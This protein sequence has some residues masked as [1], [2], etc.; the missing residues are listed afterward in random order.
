[1]LD[2]EKGITV[3]YQH[4][5]FNELLILNSCFLHETLCSLTHFKWLLFVKLVKV[6]YTQRV[7]MTTG[8]HN[9]SLHNPDYNSI[10][11][12][13][14]Q[15]VIIFCQHAFYRSLRAETYVLWSVIINK[16]LMWRKVRHSITISVPL[17]DIYLKQNIWKTI[18]CYRLFCCGSTSKKVKFL[19]EP[20]SVFLCDNLITATLT[21]G[22]ANISSPS[23]HCE[24]L[25][26]QQ[27]KYSH[28]S[29]LADAERRTGWR[30]DDD[31]LS[32][33]F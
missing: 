30:R 13:S 26:G 14:R 10:F 20:P 21:W 23:A 5:C 31:E 7:N 3:I 4:T 19:L 8:M 18:F 11:H 29:C 22:R 32:L 17:V 16:H 12:R 2:I 15:Y 28:I 24:N 6:I 33:L 25:N 27:N 9:L 1:M